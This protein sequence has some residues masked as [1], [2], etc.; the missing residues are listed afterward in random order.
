MNERKLDVLIAGAQKAGTSSLRSYL[1]A[2]RAVVGQTSFELPYFA[3]DEIFAQGWERAV[4]RYFE[5][6]RLAAGQ[7]MLAKSAG[8]AFV[9]KAVERACAHNPDMRVLMVLREPVARAFSSYRYYVARGREQS[10]SFAEALAAE[11]RRLAES[12]T[13]FH[14]LAYFRRGLYA[15]Q[16]ERLHAYFGHHQVHVLVLEEL[17]DDPVTVLGAVC[18]FLAIERWSDAEVKA[19]VA[20]RHNVTDDA[21]ARVVDVPPWA[22]SAL[23]ALFPMSVLRRVSRVLTRPRPTSHLRLEPEVRA[24]LSEQFTAPNEAL[25]KLLGRRIDAWP[26]DPEGGT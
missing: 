2:H 10:S 9:P 14:P 3:H 11:S 8:L 21:G 12:F 23:R 20:E 24:A 6:R 13:E 22:S 19:L 4:A 5:R 15:E 7:L 26:S 17:V 16:I 25:C 18:D 1:D